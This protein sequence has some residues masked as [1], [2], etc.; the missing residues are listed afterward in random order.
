MDNLIKL[1][2]NAYAFYDIAKNPP[3]PFEN[4]HSIVDIEKRFKEI[5]IDDISKYEFYRRIAS[6]LSDLKDSHIRLLFND[7][8][9]DFSEFELT[10]PFE[11]FDIEPYED[12]DGNEVP[13]IFINCLDDSILEEYFENGITL[14]RICD[15]YSDSIP[16]QSINGQDP[17]DY[18]ANFGGDFFATK[19]VH[20][21]FSFKIGGNNAISLIDCLFDFNDEESKNLKVVFEDGEEIETQYVFSSGKYIY[22]DDESDTNLEGDNNHGRKLNSMN[23]KKKRKDKKIMK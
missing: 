13:R 9:T 18:V 5:K 10:G 12:E 16:V 7:N 20:G 2:K 3:Q 17:F 23:F 6:S 14:Q 15:E 19:N 22:D 21:T 1:F 4:Y 8:V 11:S